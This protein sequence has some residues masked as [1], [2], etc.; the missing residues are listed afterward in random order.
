MT[1]DDG[2]PSRDTGRF[3]KAVILVVAGLLAICIVGIFALSGQF[4]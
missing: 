3:R 4:L 2:S 1:D